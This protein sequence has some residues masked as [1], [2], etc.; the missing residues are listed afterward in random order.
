MIR[1]IMAGM[2]AGCITACA[3][4]LIYTIYDYLKNN[5]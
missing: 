1:T 5:I 2:F 4:A 3:I